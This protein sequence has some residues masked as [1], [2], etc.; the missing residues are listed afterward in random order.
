MGSHSGDY[1]E[2]DLLGYNTKYVG[3]NSELHGVTAQKRTL[4]NEI[5]VSLTELKCIWL[6]F[7]CEV[8]QQSH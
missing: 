4:K 2:S 5:N 8:P 6:F 3:R 7:L 1:G